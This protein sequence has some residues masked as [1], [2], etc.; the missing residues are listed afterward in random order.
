M[1]VVNKTNQGISATTERAAISTSSGRGAT[2]DISA[3][4]TGDLSLT[5]Q[6]RR[7]ALRPKLT[8][9]TRSKSD[10][11]RIMPR[12]WLGSKEQACFVISLYVAKLSVGNGQTCGKSA[13]IPSRKT[14]DTRP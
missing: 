11:A 2:S 1:R 12:I 7:L 6:G 8:V 14:G 10:L 9:T 4:R 3:S 13:W 5:E